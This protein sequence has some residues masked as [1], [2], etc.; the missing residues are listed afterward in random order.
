M[1]RE[2]RIVWTAI[3]VAAAATLSLPAVAA[4][5]DQTAAICAEAQERYTGLDGK[6]TDQTNVAVVLMYKYTFC[7]PDLKVKKGTTIRFV[8]VDKRTSH[9]TWFKEAGKDES[10]RLF[11]EETWEIVLPEAGTYPYLCGPHWEREKMI[12]VIEVTE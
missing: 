5:D 7:P 11:P 8:N 9:S 12:G 3:L 2:T 1:Q 4:D 10:E 6:P